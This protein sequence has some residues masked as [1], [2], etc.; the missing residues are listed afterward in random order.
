MDFFRPPTS[1]YLQ[2][3][4]LVCERILLRAWK[5]GDRIPSVRDLA[6]ELQVNPN[7]VMRAYAELQE[8][9]II[10]NQRGVGYFVGPE[11]R[12]K[13]LAIKR[14]EFFRAELP[15]MFKTLELLVVGWSELTRLRKAPEM[16]AE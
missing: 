14:E 11:S 3:A 13:A 9:G 7:T 8:K 1:I 16:A 15:R 5:E 2:I 12:A 10:S 4:D 6:V